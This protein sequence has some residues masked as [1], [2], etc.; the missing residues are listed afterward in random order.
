MCRSSSDVDTRAIWLYANRFPAEP[1]WPCGLPI[2]MKALSDCC[3]SDT[4]VREPSSKGAKEN[5]PRRKPSGKLETSVA[6]ERG[7]SRLCRPSFA[8]LRGW[9][10]TAYTIGY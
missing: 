1:R 5:S 9:P 2:G 3:V 8:T 10:G 6:P 4:A 7:V